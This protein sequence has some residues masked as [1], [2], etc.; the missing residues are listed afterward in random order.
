MSCQSSQTADVTTRL[1][2]AC[3]YYITDTIT[4]I[5]YHHRPKFSAPHLTITIAPAMPWEAISEVQAVYTCFAS[6]RYF[7]YNCHCSKMV[8]RIINCL[9]L[10][11]FLGPIIFGG[12]NKIGTDLDS[13]LEGG[14]GS[15]QLNCLVCYQ[16]FLIKWWLGLFWGEQMILFIFKFKNIFWV[17]FKPYYGC[18]Q[19]FL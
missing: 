7:Q 10:L 18:S 1:A 16:G 19:F 17:N 12:D 3:I 2:K 14:L 11:S 6:Y 8:T 9:R 4:L 5:I 15:R 13:L